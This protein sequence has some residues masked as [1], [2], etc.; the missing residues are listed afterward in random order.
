MTADVTTSTE[1]LSDNNEQLVTLT[2]VAAEKIKSYLGQSGE[3]AAG[4]V[5]RVTIRPGGC[6]GLLQEIGFDD[7][8]EETDYFQ[9]SFGVGIVVDPLSVEYVKGLS[10][11]YVD[12]I[13]E[14]GFLLDNPN[15]QSSCACG[16]SF[17]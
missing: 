11:D 15:K 13:E 1:A 14:Q 6:A 16:N 8:N 10:I 9:E 17:C 4:K 3:E 7:R 2:P 5:L 12:T